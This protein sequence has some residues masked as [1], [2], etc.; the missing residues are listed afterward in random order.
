MKLKKKQKNK[1]LVLD[2]RRLKSTDLNYSFDPRKNMTPPT[3]IYS[4]PK[5]Y[6]HNCS[7]KYIFLCTQ[8]KELKRNAANV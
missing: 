7:I 6:S 2:P 1:P 3:M 8:K 4:S 5:I